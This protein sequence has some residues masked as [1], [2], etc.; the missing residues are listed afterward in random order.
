MLQA[1]IAVAGAFLPNESDIVSTKGRTKDSNYTYRVTPEDYF[2][3]EDNP[4]VLKNLTPQAKKVPLVVLI[5]SAS[6]SAS[7]I[8]AGALQDYHRATL[9]GNR[10]FGKGSVQTILPMRT[11]EKIVGVKLTTARYYTPSGRSIQA[12][13][14]EPDFYIDDTPK[15]NYPSFQIRESD[16]KRHLRN[17]D[18]ND[19]AKDNLPYDGD[20]GEVPD[21]QFTFGDDKDWQLQQA[22]NYLTGKPVEVSQYRGKP[23][24]V[25]EKL[26][27]ELAE[28]KAQ[29]KLNDESKADSSNGHSTEPTSAEKSSTNT[30]P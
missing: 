26:K 7:E 14:I 25:V 1:A 9:L 29:S 30:A 24:K 16:L 21:Y 11:G 28:K 27:K 6:A 10:S 5:N 2:L 18:E 20:D 17:K 19:T 15:G 3:S 13:G 4:D 8:V 12:K 22:V 23:R